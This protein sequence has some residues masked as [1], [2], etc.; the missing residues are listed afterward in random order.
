M[1][2]AKLGLKIFALHYEQIPTPKL[3]TD[4]SA[5]FWTGLTGTRYEDVRMDEQ[6]HHYVVRNSRS[7]K[8]RGKLVR[9]VQAGRYHY[10]ESL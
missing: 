5:S 10:L 6:A 1:L 8:N 4:P 7:G 9:P 2:I 3:G